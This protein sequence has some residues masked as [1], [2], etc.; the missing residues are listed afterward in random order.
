MWTNSKTWSFYKNKKLKWKRN[1]MKDIVDCITTEKCDDCKGAGV[2]QLKSRKRVDTKT[3]IECLGTGYKIDRTKYAGIRGMEFDLMDTQST[4]TIEKIIAYPKIY[5]ALGFFYT[6]NAYEL[7]YHGK[8]SK[9]GTL[10]W[11]EFCDF[12][13]NRYIKRKGLKHIFEP[14]RKTEKW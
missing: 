4:T 3:C 12:D 5:A 7:Y 11:K 6:L 1:N 9:D 2:Y 8:A 10:L 13:G 14:Y